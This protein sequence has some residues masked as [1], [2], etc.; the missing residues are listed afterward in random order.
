MFREKRIIK[1]AVGFLLLVV[2]ALPVVTTFIS[3][4]SGNQ[5]TTHVV[6]LTTANYSQY[7]KVNARYY[8]GGSTWSY[9]VSGLSYEQRI[10]DV[11]V[12]PAASYLEFTGYC[13]MQVKIYG[14]YKG[15]AVNSDTYYED[16]TLYVKLDIGGN[17][18]ASKYNGNS[19]ARDIKGV[20]YEVVS[21]TGGVVVK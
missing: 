2:L 8:G 1:R 20:S 21:I 16:A 12:S 15:V 3:C 11:S 17:G 5:P 4:G 10:F 13:S 6:S 9:S 18:R 7:L 19:S 14:S